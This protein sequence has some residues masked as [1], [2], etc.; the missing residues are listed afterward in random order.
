[1][2]K[3][4]H[5]RR[6]LS[7]KAFKFIAFFCW[8]VVSPLAKAE[9]DLS[10]LPNG[11]YTLDKSHAS[12]VWKISHLGLS[13]YVA[14]FTR[15]DID[16]ILNTEDLTKSSVSAL[17]DPTSISTENKE[18]DK[19][20]I[21]KG[22]FKTEKFP[23]IRFVSSTYKRSSD[24]Q[25]KLTGILEMFGVKKPVEFDVLIGGTVDDHPFISNSVGIGFTA[26]TIIKRSDWGFRKFLS[27]VGD[28]VTIE[29][30]AEFSKE[31]EKED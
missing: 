21:G 10:K 26:K 1:M 4:Q 2:N 25:G 6:N 31:K 23:S 20:L 28:E 12:I 17:I 29:I 18:F 7:I 16:L 14:R 3:N 8:F 24:N 13:P 15:F 30:A 5:F 19:D 27:A 9:I 22:W 11:L